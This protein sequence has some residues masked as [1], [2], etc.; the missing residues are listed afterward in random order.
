M[1]KTLSKRVEWFTQDPN[2]IN[3]IRYDWDAGHSY[4]Y[5]DHPIV[6]E[7]EGDEELE[8]RLSEWMSENEQRPPC[9]IYVDKEGCAQSGCG[10]HDDLTSSEVQ[11]VLIELTEWEESEDNDYLIIVG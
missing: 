10:C 11:E 6:V 8:E 1:S 7:C 5:I 3:S 2:S 4:S 9:A